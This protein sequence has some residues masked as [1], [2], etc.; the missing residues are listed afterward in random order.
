MLVTAINPLSEA[1]GNFAAIMTAFV[2]LY[3]LV[4]IIITYGLY[5]LAKN[6]R[7]RGLRIVKYATLVEF[8]LFMTF[9]V[10]TTV[11]F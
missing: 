8:L 9:L 6:N 7:E 10:Y 2:W 11:G 4:F 3:P 5:R 1:Q